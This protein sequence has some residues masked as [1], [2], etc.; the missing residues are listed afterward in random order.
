MNTRLRECEILGVG[1]YRPRHV[2]ANTIIAEDCG[3][4][5][6]WI[7][8]RTGIRSR[9]FAGPDE[10]LASMAVSAAHEAFVHARTD[11]ADIDL[12][13]LAS[14]TNTRQVPALAPSVAHALG[15]RRAMALDLSSACSGFCYSLAAARDFIRVGTAN[16]ALIIGVERMT[17]VVDP[18]DRATAPIFGDGAGAAVIGPAHEPGVGP[19]IWGSDGAGRGAISMSAPWDTVVHDPGAATPH[20]DMEGGDVWR[21]IRNEVVPALRLAVTAAGLDPEDLAAFIPHQ[22]NGRIIDMLVKQIELPA[23]IRVAKDIEH[24]GN[25]SAASIPLAMHALLDSGAVHS[26]QYALLAGFGAGLTHAAQVVRLP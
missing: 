1:S 21:W 15:A 6:S 13:I 16:R 24:T 4:T 7:T 20:L 26:G 19:V 3:V 9:R 14:L 25:T 2:V 17:D 11:P 5:D 10:T 8:T 23:H 18:T 22:A 12:V